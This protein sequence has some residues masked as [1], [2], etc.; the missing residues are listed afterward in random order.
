MASFEKHEI[1]YLIEAFENIKEGIEV[2]EVVETL[3]KYIQELKKGIVKIKEV[4]KNFLVG[5]FEM[6]LEFGSH[7]EINFINKLAEKL[8][9]KLE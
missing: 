7:S 6:G 3:E 1:D 2:E 9:I 8:E 4:D 5:Y